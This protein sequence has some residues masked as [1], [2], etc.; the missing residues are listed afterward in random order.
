MARKRTLLVFFIMALLI[1]VCAEDG[2]GFF[3]KIMDTIR[4]ILSKFGLISG[5]EVD[6]YD[7]NITCTP[8][9]V[10][11]NETCCLDENQ[12][13]LCDSDET[14][15]TMPTITTSTPTT[16]TTSTTIITTTSTTTTLSGLP[17]HC[18]TNKDCGE[19]TEERICYRGNVHIKRE[20][21]FCRRPGRPD[22]NCIFKITGITNAFGV[23]AP[24]EKCTGYCIM[25]ECVFM[26]EG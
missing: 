4:S 17:E 9:Y 10:S 7:V 14:T 26:P 21:P 11:I 15:T 22:S 20:V 18:K 13:G 6:I 8:L 5:E 16:S 23:P 25:G 3:T 19:V 24:A 12:N 2:K 1:T